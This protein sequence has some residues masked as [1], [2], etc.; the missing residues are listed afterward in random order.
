MFMTAR[1]FRQGKSAMQSGMAKSGVWLLEFNLED[2]KTIEPLMGW[3]G[4]NETQNQVRLQF[5]S[6]E[7]AIAYANKKGIDYEVIINQSRRPVIRKNGYGENFATD[8]KG[9]WTH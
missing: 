3:T 4:S 9:A 7:E 5:L 2:T 8:R 6:K 1:I